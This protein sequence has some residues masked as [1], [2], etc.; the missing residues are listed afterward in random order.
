[1]GAG[2]EQSEAVNS[3]GRAGANGSGSASAGAAAAVGG[4]SNRRGRALGGYICASG[5]AAHAMIAHTAAAPSCSSH[6]M[7]IAACL[8]RR[9]R[10]A[11]LACGYIR[12]GRRLLHG[13]A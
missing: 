12:A 9:A 5:L 10:A 3:H 11:S 1:M 6:R 2:T 7:R 8:K 13:D 4:R